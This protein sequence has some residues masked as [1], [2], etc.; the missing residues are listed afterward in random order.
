MRPFRSLP[1]LPVALSVALPLAL[2]LAL[3][4]VAVAGPLEPAVAQEP[5]G[6]RTTDDTGLTRL[7]RQPDIHGDLVVFVYGGDLW[8]A[9]AAGG[10]ATRLTSHEG[11]EQY[12][13]ISPDGRTIA[14]TA[15]YSGT[16]QVH[17]MSVDGGT[18]RQLTFY[19][20]V[21]DLPPRGGV[22][23]R[24]LDWTPDGQRIVFGAHRLP[25]GPRMEIPY[26]VPVDGG[27][28]EPLGVPEG[29]AVSMAPDGN[30]IAYTPVSREYR[31]WKRH[32]GGRAQDVWTY[33]LAADRSEQI[34]D[35]E[36]TD[37][38]PVWVDG[39]IYFTSDRTGTLQ[40]W[41]YD[42]GS[43]ET[44]QATDHEGWDVLWPSGGPGAVVYEAGGW[45]WRHDPA[46]G[47]SRRIPIR[48]VGDFAGRLPYF[49]D[50]A[51]LVDGGD[52]SPSGA[53]A[54][55]GAHGEVFTVPAKNGEVRNLTL[56]PGV[57]ERDPRW[58]P[59][60]RWISYWSDATGEYELY[61]RPADGT[62][63]ARR[64]TDD[65]DDD[66]VWRREARWS[67]DSRF[68]A[69]SDRAA[70][71]RV[72]D[73]SS[74]R[75]TDVARSEFG[76]IT[77]HTWS[78]DSRWLAYTR[79]TAETQLPSVEVWS[80]ESGRTHRL[81]S[82]A[83]A[84]FGPAWD[85]QGRYLYFLSNRDFNLTFSGFEFDFLYT[86]PTRVYVG[87]L[88]ED[89]PALFL[90]RSDEEEVAG[91]AA[92][93]A[94]NGGGSGNG[95]VVVEIDPDGFERRVRAIPG[96]PGGYGN[97]TGV[98]AGVLYM[99]GQ[100]LRLYD[101]EAR[102]EKTI[103]EGVANYE[104]AAGGEKV[105]YARPGP[106]G[107]GYGIAAL[108]PDQDAAAGMLDLSG[109]EV[110]V[111][112][113]AL[114]AQ[115]FDDAWRIF[116]DWFY[117]EDMHGLDW[118][119]MRAKYEPLVAH[120]VHR[121]DLDYILGELGGELGAGHVYIQS[122]P[123]M[124][125]ERRD[126]ALLGAE[127]VADPS[128]YF[129]IA[130]IFP[131]ENWHADFRSPLTEP[132]VDV[133]EGD[134]ITAIDG[135]STRGVDNVYRLLQNKGDRVVTLTVA[136]RPGGAT[137]EER[138][139]PVT[140][141]TNLRYLA[142]VE[143]RRRYV[144]E[145]SDGRIG[146]IHLPNTAVEG[147]RELFKGFYAAA[148]RDGLILD[149]RYNGGG[150]IPFHMIELLSRPLLSYWVQRDSRP[151]TTPG[152]YHRGPKV[153]LANAYSGSGGDAFPFYFRQQGLGPVVGTR[154]WGGLIGL[155]GN[156]SLMDGG[157]VLV[158]TFR[159]VTPEGEFRIENEGVTPDYLVIDRP[160]LV[161]QGIDPSLDRAIQLILEELERNP[162]QGLRI[163]G[164]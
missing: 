87:M 93:G 158:P 19:N 13:K 108:Q 15:D 83:S 111:D 8:R 73:V 41:A 141:E 32:R 58:S 145:R 59:D 88:A 91:G 146:Y 72:V 139:R 3:S 4:L 76:D 110:R 109:L 81:T 125:T 138:V 47:Q 14:F 100:A 6:D 157:A 52:L 12:P 45:I 154:T 133:D 163:P 2:A 44:R 140:Q 119:A 43:G 46:S 114:W 149:A 124:G 27:M 16:R 128:G 23:N 164:R 130:K 38:Q 122:P 67:P 42:T 57:R 75:T 148:Q 127:I 10:T 77:D 92:G 50:V 153:A 65:G 55:L 151:F 80:R 78:P 89:G 33:D 79:A 82:D 137:R 120:A 24:V 51:S 112:P 118:D 63:E 98:D 86:D 161:K 132:G 25:W 68:L 85:P 134:L 117:D 105:L 143:S 106:G 31:T 7:L 116:R 60:G 11:M 97:L 48:V 160:E 22:D 70:R 126:G 54:V 136:D 84:E 1:T 142:W 152:F 101:L 34:T 5:L 28:E 37:N 36:G 123:G 71:L 56:T 113:P 69:W 107:M 135:V 103:L 74:G 40:L 18:P 131:G 94:G 104:V 96:S 95:D 155:S 26:T 64:V 156:P 21:G 162:V 66:P 39:T 102:E 99:E 62:G 147:N 90:P 150:F 53:R 29:S 35:F 115:E 129:R 159:F 121:S 20:D 49:R 30:R 144:E 17:V 61:V 9:S